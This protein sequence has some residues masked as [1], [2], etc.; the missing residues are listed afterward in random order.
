MYSIEHFPS[1]VRDIV[2]RDCRRHFTE[3]GPENA[4]RLDDGTSPEAINAIL[5]L[6]LAERIAKERGVNY[7]AAWGWQRTLRR[8]KAAVLGYES[9]D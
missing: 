2:Q 4:I 1:V 6:E 7:D 9:D 5:G 3:K 8:I